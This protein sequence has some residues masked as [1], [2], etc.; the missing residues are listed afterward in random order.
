MFEFFPKVYTNICELCNNTCNIIVI[1]NFLP[2]KYSGRLEQQHGGVVFQQ[3][4]QFP[5][6]KGRLSNWSA[7]FGW[8]KNLHRDF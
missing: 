2:Y 6:D 5:T 8:C 7:K 1:N 3:Y 4:L